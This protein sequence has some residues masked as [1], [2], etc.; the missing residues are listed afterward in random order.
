MTTTGATIDD[1]VGIMIHDNS[2]FA[3]PEYIYIYIYIYMGKWI[4][5]IDW[6]HC[7]DHNKTKHNKTVCIFYG[8][9]LAY[10]KGWFQLKQ[11]KSCKAIKS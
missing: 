7:Y 4:V 5:S 11:L 2:R 9:Y 10:N 6:E 1:E 3:V 8:I